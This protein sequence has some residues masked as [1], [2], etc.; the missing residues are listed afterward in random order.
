M[1]RT[2]VAIS[3]IPSLLLPAAAIASQPAVV[4]STS[5]ANSHTS[6]GLV[7]PTV[8]YSANIVRPT[9]TFSDAV[10]MPAQ[11]GLK[12]KVD[13]N[14]Q[15]EDIQV[16]HSLTPEWDAHVVAAVRQYRFHPA[17]LDN[18]PVPMNINLFVNIQR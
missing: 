6:T 4:A 7:A 16:I 8:V 13:E 10:P 14:G 17:T 3:L 5:T 1:R 18:R 11:V 2:L 9:G 15:A 12:L